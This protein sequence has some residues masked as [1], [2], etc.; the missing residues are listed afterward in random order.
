MLSLLSEWI[1]GEQLG[2]D[3]DDFR[4]QG[5]QDQSVDPFACIGPHHQLRRNQGSDDAANGKR[6]GR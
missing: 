4:A 3:T 5:E 6:N 2:S 1:S